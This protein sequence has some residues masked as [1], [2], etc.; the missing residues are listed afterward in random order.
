ME[1]D[2]QL[3]QLVYDNLGAYFLLGRSVH[4]VQKKWD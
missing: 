2:Q 3:L 4:C 1:T